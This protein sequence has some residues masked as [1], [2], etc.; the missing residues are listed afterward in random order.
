MADQHF[1]LVSVPF[2]ASGEQ[3]RSSQFAQ[4]QAALGPL[5]PVARLF[6]IPNL[7]VGT[8][9]SLLEASDELT[10]LDPQLEGTCFK[11]AGILED[12]SGSSRAN[13]TMLRVNPQSNDVAS[14]YFLKDF[15]WNSAMYDPK[16][17]ISS[18]LSKF[19]HVVSGADERTRAS[20]TEFA[21]LKNKL[22]S[23]ARRNAGTLGVRPIGDVVRSWCH[24]QGMSEPVESEF[25]T[26]IFVAVPKAQQDDFNAKYPSFHEF[27]V[28]KS[29]SVVSSDSEFI[30]N[31]VVVFKKVAEDF[32]IQCR[33]HKFMVRDLT[34]G[35]DLSAEET[36]ELERKVATDKSKLTLLLAQQFT[37]CYVAWVHAKA[38]RVFV[39]SMLRFGLPP[40]FVPVIIAADAKKEDEVRA[41][42][43]TLYADYANKFQKGEE[44]GVVDAGALQHEFPFVSL[45]VTNILKAR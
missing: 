25:L 22:A 37:H 24:A 36:G 15:S 30:L 6:M 12:V 18:L 19:A 5:G 43:T 40:K 10:K 27:V 4:L 42:L 7:K 9:D 28:P 34:T 1:T 33:K 39:E 21:E 41:K 45:K 3:Q 29:G 13:V 2:R 16:E 31:A 44:G 20:L 38:V 35:D 14:D 23:A 11:L 8:L 26:T 32:K 17:S